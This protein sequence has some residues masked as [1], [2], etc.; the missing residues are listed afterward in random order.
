MDLQ[1]LARFM[2]VLNFFLPIF[3]FL[4]VFTNKDKSFFLNTCMDKGYLSF[5][6]TDSKFCSYDNPYKFC[7]CWVWLSILSIGNSE[8]Q[9]NKSVRIKVQLIKIRL[10]DPP[11]LN[12]FHFGLKIKWKQGNR[13]FRWFS[14]IV[15]WNFI[16]F[17]LGNGKCKQM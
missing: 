9:I 3:S 8:L 15:E 14:D 16:L 7:I 12:N 13:F 5:F 1:A 6:P 2:V 17:C 10:N 4:F 11:L